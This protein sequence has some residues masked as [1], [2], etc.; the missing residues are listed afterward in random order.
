MSA[1]KAPTGLLGLKWGD[2]AV[3]GARKL[4][5]V[6]DH[7]YL[8]SDPGFE[9]SLDAAHPRSVLGV[10]GLVL[11]VRAGKALEGIQ[12][13]YHD[14]AKND[15]QRKQLREGLRRELH[16]RSADSDV[17]YDVWED[18]SLVR[19][20]TDQRDGTCTLTVAGPRFGKVYADEILR[21]GLGNLGNAMRPH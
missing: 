19:L 17:P 5:L 18:K 14:C 7:W 12:V 21:G 4:G 16:V 6:Y 3:E 13:I 1:H 11:L 15:V 10:E 9:S 8:W 2:D 20:D